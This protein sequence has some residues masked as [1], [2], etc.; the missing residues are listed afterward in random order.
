[1]ENV[2][3]I[4][5]NSVEK[6]KLFMKMYP[7]DYLYVNVSGGKDSSAVWGIVDKAT[8]DYVVFF[9]HIPGQSHYD[10]VTAVYNMAKI[11][12]VKDIVKVKLDKTREMREKIKE[13]ISS[14][15]RP[16]LIHAVV[17]DTYGEDFWRAMQRYG[18][19]A[20]LER[21][22]A[23]VRWCCGTFKHRTLGH[24]PYNGKLDG[25]EWHFGVD[26]TK[27]TD[28]PYRTKVYKTCIITWEKTRDTYLFPIRTLTDDEVWELLK[29]M[30]LYEVVHVQ[31]EKWGR[32]PNCMWCPMVSSKELMKK[33]WV[34][35][36]PGGRELVKKTLEGMMNKYKEST[37]SFK[38]IKKWLETFE[39]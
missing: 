34:N 5:S 37:F 38:E 8:R 3:S 11:L 4:L 29:V 18:F 13:A 16:C 23:G 30:G 25:K 7:M 27:A 14:C 19:P 10:N 36:S 12:N 9:I 24:L 20:P 39:Q 31:Y 22:G 28:S 17:F 33:T 26:G 6:V 21:F 35:M 1:M 32:S 2:S 15:G